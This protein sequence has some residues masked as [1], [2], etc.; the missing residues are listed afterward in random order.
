MVAA[1]DEPLCQRYAGWVVSIRTPIFF[2]GG[3]HILGHPGFMGN[4]VGCPGARG[5][6]GI[7]PPLHTSADAKFLCRPGFYRRVE[8]LPAEPRG[9]R[10]L[11]GT[12]EGAAEGSDPASGGLA[13]GTLPGF[14]SRDDP[15][16]APAFAPRGD[17]ILP[18]GLCGHDGGDGIPGGEGA[19]PPLHGRVPLPWA[20]PSAP[21][22]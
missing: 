17:P 16:A 18:A 6:E 9:D 8:D 12:A 19:V 3:D 5:A 14:N 20:E 10:G 11:P 15:G 7:S 13:S 2:L 22:L 1:E 21:V 4:A